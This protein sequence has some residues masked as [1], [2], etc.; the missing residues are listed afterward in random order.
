MTD[1]GWRRERISTTRSSVS[2]PKATSVLFL[3]ERYSF[4][5]DSLGRRRGELVA[6]TEATVEEKLEQRA[7]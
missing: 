3:L 5:A 7:N 6:A 1:L 2:L 4:I